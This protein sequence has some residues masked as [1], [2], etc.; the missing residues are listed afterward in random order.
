MTP[1]EP[2]E[3]LRPAASGP[4][5]GAPAPRFEGPAGEGGEDPG[6]AWMLAFQAGDEAAFEALVRHYSAP[7]FR[8]LTRFLG[9][10]PQREDLVQEVFLR[11]FKARDRYEPSARF[12]TFLY[13]IAFNLSANEREKARHREAR[14]LSDDG[15]GQR[16]AEPADPDSPDPSLGLERGDVSAAVRSAIEALPAKQRMALLLAK[17]DD[18]PHDEIARVLDLT[19]PAVKSLIHRAR[20]TLRARLS[21]FLLEQSA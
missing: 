15:S 8:L 20:E 17:F 2:H 19:V 4:G 1:P 6:T 3:T 13:R 9:P 5:S 11:V 7:L 10:V 14:S 21:P 18:L 12:S 16:P